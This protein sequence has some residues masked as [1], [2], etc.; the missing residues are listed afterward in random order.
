MNF[1]QRALTSIKRNTRKSIILFV[2]LLAL[3]SMM[4][5]AIL[6]N[7]ATAN[8]ERNIINNMQPSAIIGLDYLAIDQ[9]N[10]TR[11]PRGEW[12]ETAEP[13]PLAPELI[14]AIGSLSYVS[15]YEYF[16]MGYF[17]APTLTVYEPVLNDVPLHSQGPEWRFADLGHRYQ[18]RGVQNPDFL[19]L[20][21][22]VI[23]IV[24]GR[25]FT[26]GELDNLSLVAMISEEFAQL[27]QLTVGSTMP[28]RNVVFDP[29]KIPFSLDWSEQNAVEME[30]YDLEIIGIFRTTA[31]GRNAGAGEVGAPPWDVLGQMEIFGNRIYTPSNFVEMAKE[32]SAR[33]AS[34][35][36][37]EEIIAEDIDPNERDSAAGLYIM[38]QHSAREIN[39][40]RLENFFTLRDP[41]YIVPFRETVQ[42]MLPEFYLVAIA[43]NN[44]DEI[45]LALNTLDSLASMVLYVTMGA[46]LLIV[47]LLIVLFLRDRKHEMGIYL[48][49][50]EKRSRIILQ[51]IVEVI[52][53]ALFA[54]LVALFIGNLL[55]GRLGEHMLLNDLLA[56]VDE[57]NE[58][59]IVDLFFRQGLTGELS[60]QVIANSYDLSFSLFTVLAFLGIGLGTVLLATMVP[61]F[62][63]LRLNPK[64]IMM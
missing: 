51:M 36:V 28:I 37:I 27:N 9:Y 63:I 39:R 19:E 38:S 33:I 26:R 30:F 25:T 55:A 21:Q 42:E 13:L 35:I 8:T 10:D 7:Q 46:M 12:W 56:I 11:G 4:A 5:G 24:A 1:I 15:H 64:K 31:I 57:G 17:F 58:L 52:V 62:Y 49:I 53:V 59:Q 3:G 32:S 41:N 47:S 16:A 50:G 54:L 44:F 23:E 6:V 43:E 14:Q 18:I 60:M 45:L 34:E 20:R 29:M 2:L 22:G 48:S 61:V 40:L